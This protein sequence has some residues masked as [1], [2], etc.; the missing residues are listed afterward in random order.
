MTLVISMKKVELLA[1]A[2]SFEALEAAVMCGADAVYLGGTKFGARA[3]AS[4][5]DNENIIKAVN[6]A[7]LYGVK[8]YVTVNTLIYDDEVSSFLDYITYL[9]SIG[10]DAFI[11]QDLGMMHLLRSIY[12]HLELHASTQMHIHNIESILKLKELGVK[13]VVLPREFSLS[14]VKSLKETS[15]M[16]I[17]IFVHGALCISYSGQCLMSSLIGGRSGNRGECAGSCRLAY[18]LVE[19][20]DNGE[21]IIN[22]NGDYP[23]STKDLNTL[24]RIDEIIESGVDSLKIEGRM[25]RAE[26]VA[27]VTTLYRKAI[28]AYYEGKKY[29]VTEEDLI[30]LKKMYNRDFTK[31]Y[32]FG[33]KGKTLMNPIRPNHMG[34]NLGR[35]IKVDNKYITI[36]LNDYLSIG[37]G[38][39]ILSNEDIGFT[40][41]KIYKNN[42]TV[43]I[44]YKE[45]I[46]SF[47]K[48]GIVNVNDEVVKTT[49][50]K[51]I[52]KIKEFY[53]NSNRKIKIAGIM[54]A[55][56]GKK[57]SFTVSDSI[58]NITLKSDIIVSSA[59]N[60]PVSKDIILEKL[61]KI[62]DTPYI[63]EN[64]NINMDDNIFIPL[65]EINALKRET[66]NRLS[67]LRI[68]R[69]SNN[70]KND[71]SLNIP[72]T[73]QNNILLKSKIK[74][75]E[76]Y[77]ACINNDIDE[78]YVEDYNLYQNIKNDKK[79]VLAY[80]SVRKIKTVEDN[81][82]VGDIGSISKNKITDY[83]LN[84]VNSYTA[85]F[86]HSLGSK[87]VTL[88]Y[89]MNMDKISLLIINY[90][91]VF[92][93]LP[94]LEVIIYGRIEAMVSEYC[95]LNT[96][97]YKN[98]VCNI[99]KNG[100]KYYLRD[101]FKN[102]YVLSFNNCI[103]S[104]YNYKKLNIIDNINKLIGYGINNFRLN[105]VDENYEEC[106]KIIKEVKNKIK[107][108]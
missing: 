103:M 60:K 101:R 76:Q 36:K 79:I 81:A 31:G 28:D 15:G 42:E 48:T 22:T 63:F 20:D 104:V 107:L 98:G 13:R 23:L 3:Y 32:L 46:V 85:A 29:Q 74:T 25:K 6:Y 96:Y 102:D 33:D 67:E 14:K 77:K 38:I 40:V 94:N 91:K 65:A 71:Y 5:F 66:L 78:I 30:D 58:N 100:K 69:V 54:N 73:F 97:L 9:D 10:V 87:T 61:N 17:E 88:S 27:I 89:E 62:G 43:N 75:M 19:K 90:K 18:K 39:R 44:A 37:D 99:C 16:D 84:V 92:N 34:T 11:I 72:D 49:D 12:P 70:T 80:P 83:S 82:L 68:K 47:D 64:I 4:N 86:L 26:Y 56:I 41:N 108:K 57:L 35:V 53:Q 8:I 93:K 52:D 45:D 50:V 7:H 24:D 95:P 51:L 106:S 105:F 21:R 1:P 2:G 59:Q 55:Y